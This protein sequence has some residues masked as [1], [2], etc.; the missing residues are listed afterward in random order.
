MHIQAPC[1]LGHIAITELIHALN[2]FPTHA[3]STHRVFGRW[4]EIIITGQKRGGYV[5]CIRW[6]RQIISRANLYRSD[7]S[8][9]RTIT[10][11]N[12]NPRIGPFRAECFHNI[13]AIA[14]FKPQI[15]NA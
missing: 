1:R 2:M 10:R 4:G 8:C 9:N 3:V 13:Q 15:D 14:I 11:Q 12:D 5:I 6:F 7:R